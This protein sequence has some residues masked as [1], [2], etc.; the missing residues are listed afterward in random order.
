MKPNCTSISSSSCTSIKKGSKHK[1][2]NAA[3]Q[4]LLERPRRPLSAYNLFFQ[5]ER[6]VL[7]ESLPV[8]KQ[9]KPLRSHGKIGFRDMAKLIGQKWRTLDPKD[10]APFEAM[11]KRNKERQAKE[12]AAYKKRL[13][14]KNVICAQPENDT[15]GTLKSVPQKEVKPFEYIS[16]TH[17]C[18]GTELKH[19]AHTKR[20][21]TN[22]S[23]A[24][25]FQLI[26][27]I[28][29]YDRQARIRHQQPMMVSVFP[30]TR[31]SYD[32]ELQSL[33]QFE[34]DPLLSRSFYDPF[35]EPEHLGYYENKPDVNQFSA[36][37]YEYT[38]CQK[39]R[40]DSLIT[41]G[42]Q[43]QPQQ[44]QGSQHVFDWDFQ[45]DF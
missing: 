30:Q 5:H 39:D 45:G 19:D 34:E 9:G 2:C 6:K 44:Q 4:Q 32:Q 28:S 24:C 7:L 22:L 18:T 33:T 41:N 17:D 31:V 20:S 16:T 3:G 23:S 37:R 42:Y 26:P 25:P 13:F 8:R 1:N 21:G 38:V 40:P 36:T 12:M 10:K 11:A 27:P 43:C 15:S 35:P 14:Y 29:Y